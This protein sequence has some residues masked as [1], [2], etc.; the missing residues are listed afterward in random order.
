MS[1]VLAAAKEKAVRMGEELREEFG[2]RLTREDYIRVARAFHSAVVPKRK[3]GR[4]LKPQVT[5]AYQDWKAGTRGVALC[6]KHIP[7]WQKHNRYRRMAEQKS[8]MDAIR[9]RDRREGKST[10]EAVA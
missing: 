1:E 4:R 7:G 9:S 2:Q 3:P 8:L 10:R 6:A 5:A